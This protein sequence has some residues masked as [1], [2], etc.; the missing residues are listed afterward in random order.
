MYEEMTAVHCPTQELWDAVK[1][2]SGYRQGSWFDETA[3]IRLSG[4]MGHNHGVEHYTDKGFTILSAEEYLN[5]NPKTLT[6]KEERPMKK[7]I[8]DVFEKTADAVLVEQELNSEI[9]E[10]FINGLNIELFKENILTEAKR[11]RDEREAQ[12]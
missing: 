5:E 12:K 8:T 7:N 3:H 11:R 4:G 10:G 1:K 9:Q 2:K 6:K